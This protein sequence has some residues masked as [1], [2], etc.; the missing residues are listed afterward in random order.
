[1]FIEIIKQNRVGLN[2]IRYLLALIV[3]YD[4]SF[5]MGG[6]G[7]EPVIYSFGE[8]SAFGQI[9]VGGFFVLSGFLITISAQNNSFA[10][11]LISRFLRIWPGLVALLL[12]TIVIIGPLFIILENRDI[13]SYL[14]NFR[15]NGPY[16]YFLHNLSLPVI[17]QDNLDNVF[18]NVPN[19]LKVNGSLWTLPLEI[20]A[21]FICYVLIS[22][23]KKLNL[24]WT[25][26]VFEIL[27]TFYIVMKNF[28]ITTF[29]YF[30]PNFIWINAWSYWFFIFFFGS[31][32]A[33]YFQTRIYKNTYSIFT[34]SL[35][36]ITLLCGGVIFKTIGAG[37]LIF[38][39]PIFSQ[40]LKLNKLR[41]FIN[42]IS[43]GTYIYGYVI[44]QTV[45]YIYPDS[46][47][48]VY[49]FFFTT[50]SITTVCALLSWF[51]VEKPAL[52]IKQTFKSLKK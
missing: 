46:F 21:Y 40:F 9:A 33:I 29:D 28:N 18:D 15:I 2:F 27:L 24:L 1:M 4:H 47:P 20:R 35:F 8:R 22:I 6:F 19:F 48:N 37:L 17:L 36:I 23:G 26:L 11:F 34:V 5:H 45:I 3:I 39:F 43:Y 50:A 7:E 10:D 25:I 42:D 38:I 31:L 49:L 52:G 14:Q 12:F 51:Y 41:F 30:V 44:G 32:T 13:Y 16:S